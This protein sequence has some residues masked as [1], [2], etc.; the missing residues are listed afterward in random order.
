LD[1]VYPS[2]GWPA[3]WREETCERVMYGCDSISLIRFDPV[4]PRAPI[5]PT[6]NALVEVDGAEEADRRRAGEEVAEGMARGEEVAEAGR[7]DSAR[8]PTREAAAD[9]DEHTGDTLGWHDLRTA[10]RV[11]V[12]RNM[13]GEMEMVVGGSPS[14]RP[15]F[16]VCVIGGVRGRA[17]STPF[18]SIACERQVTDQSQVWARSQ[19]LK[20]DV[21]FPVEHTSSPDIEPSEADDSVRR[22]QGTPDGY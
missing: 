2:R 8:R 9:R 1:F 12:R 21:L 13:A 22:Y 19:C 20:S 3:F 14:R 18:D 17:S 15:L 4:N 6:L 10:E 7:E 5:S 16:W 11:G